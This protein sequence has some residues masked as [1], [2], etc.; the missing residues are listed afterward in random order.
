MF[1]C[2]NMRLL[3]GTH[4]P[5]CAHRGEII[6]HKNVLLHLVW[7]LQLIWQIIIRMALICY[8]ASHEQFAPSHLL[9]L[10]RLAEEAGFDGIHSS[11]HFHPWSER[12]GQSGFTLS[13]IAAAMQS[14]SLPFSM[15][16]I[17]GQRLHPAIAAQAM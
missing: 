10:V 1:H 11:D 9:K 2:K 15:I 8:H 14:T 12:Q 5:L 3:K 6:P 13:W 17:P 7:P 4:F 16:C